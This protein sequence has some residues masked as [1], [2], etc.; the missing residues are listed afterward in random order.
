M[1]LSI[2]ESRES[3]IYKATYVLPTISRPDVL[4]ILF[5]KIYGFYD[6]SL[7]TF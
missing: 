3:P 7:A 1:P 4:F 5:T 6:E 2:I